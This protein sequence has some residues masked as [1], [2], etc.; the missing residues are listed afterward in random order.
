MSKRL[1]GKVAII[2]GAGRGIGR[3]IA[4]A[5]AREGAKVVVNDVNGK[6]ASTVAEEIKVRGNE[7]LAIQADVSK[8][9]Q[10]EK[11][12]KKTL[13]VFGRI[14]ILVNNAGVGVE[15]IGPP[16]SELTE[17]EWDRNYEV[18]LKAHFLTCKAIL[19]L[20]I[21]QN[22]GKIINMSSMGGKIGSPSIPQYTSIKAGVI[23]FTE[24]LAL[25]GAPYHVNVNAI[26]PGIVRTPMFLKT[27]QIAA[28]KH[29]L[30]K[31]MDI[32]A[33]FDASVQAMIPM[34]TEQ[35]PEDIAMLAVFLASN[36]SDQITGQAIN[37]DGGAGLH[38][39][40]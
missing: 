31:G 33:V 5:F 20:M 22:K 18:N 16:L 2:T 30:M 11:M 28:G 13:Q 1:K 21:K 25:E 14:D 23:N 29:P 9:D 15:N 8:N 34:K 7:A 32:N 39:I 10:V 36:E 3:G 12:V 19:P 17:A 6:E 4:I 37:I 35:T 24:S 27:C 40:A 26:C 38:Q